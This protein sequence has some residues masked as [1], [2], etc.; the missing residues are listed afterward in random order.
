MIFWNFLAKLS[1]FSFWVLLFVI[2][3]ISGIFL[4]FP[5]FQKSQVF[6]RLVALEATNAFTLWQ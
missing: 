2:P 1:K 6:N 4:K 5:N 3:S